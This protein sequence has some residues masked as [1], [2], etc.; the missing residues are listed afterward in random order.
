MT[1]EAF[2]PPGY[3]TIAGIGPYAVPFPYDAGAVTATIDDD[4]STVVLTSGDITLTPILSDTSGNLYLSAPVATA[5]AG[6]RLYIS[7]STATEQGW[8]GQMTRELGLEAQLDLIVMAVQEIAATLSRT[9]RLF[10]P[11]PPI[12]PQ[13][14]RALIGGPGGT[15]LTNGPTASDIA[16]AQ[17]NA[18]NA[19][20]AAAAAAASAAAAAT[21]NPSL[22]LTKAG[23]LSGL[24][25][26][27]AALTTNLGFSAYMAGLRGTASLTALQSALGLASPA[28]ALKTNIAF[29]DINGAAVRLS[30]EGYGTPTD[31][32]L[33]TTLWVAGKIPDL[34][35]NMAIDAVGSYV[36]AGSSAVTS[37]AWTEGTVVAGSS[38][39]YAGFQRSTAWTVDAGQAADALI[40][41]A[42]LPGSWICM[43]R[44]G[45]ASSAARL[46]LFKRIA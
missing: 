12:S 14:G 17:T 13:E 29:T 9:I 2:T 32:E 39:R 25:D 8:Q 22:Y 4:G 11:A 38:L 36:L 37:T 1:V 30:T 5:H 24:A 6:A 44:V 26:A 23:N 40:G 42:S 43:G 21:F 28:L 46:S 16:T 7:R 27:V 20:A 19:L 45:Y 41:A 18:A 31:T 35:A 10:E 3:Y 15:I 34:L 33:A